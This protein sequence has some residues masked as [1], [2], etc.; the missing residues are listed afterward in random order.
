MSTG[1]ASV[2]GCKDTAS[3][4]AGQPG[5]GCQQQAGLHGPI[6]HPCTRSFLLGGWVQ[7]LPFAHLGLSPAQTGQA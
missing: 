5:E 1:L 7:R 4:G 3:H 6:L 2:Y